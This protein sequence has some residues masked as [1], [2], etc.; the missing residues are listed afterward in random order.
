MLRL[1][2]A[3][4]LA[5]KQNPLYHYIMKRNIMHR[6]GIIRVNLVCLCAAFGFVSCNLMF[7][8]PFLNCKFV[9]MYTANANT[10]DITNMGKRSLAIH[11]TPYSVAQLS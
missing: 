7:F 2:F 8:S 1:H 6:V 5:A 9:F 11:H 3:L 4:N 10:A